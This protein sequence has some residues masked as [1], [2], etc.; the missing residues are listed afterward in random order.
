MPSGGN[1]QANLVTCLE[2]LDQKGEAGLQEELRRIHP[3]APH[4]VETPMGTF[5]SHSG[6]HLEVNKDTRRVR[7]IPN[8][9]APSK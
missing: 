1:A 2:A 8:P 6:G 5:S 4:E 9:H 3:A 7:F